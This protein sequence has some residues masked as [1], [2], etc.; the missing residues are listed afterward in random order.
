MML[1]TAM[2][3]CRSGDNPPGYASGDM[4]A[5]N[6]RWRVVY[7][8]VGQ[9]YVM[10][11]SPATM[12]VFFST[13]LVNAAVHRL[14]TLFRGGGIALNQEKLTNRFPEVR[15]QTLGVVS[16]PGAGH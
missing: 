14:C 12:N 13:Q 7:R 16:A 3:A 8:L 2:C 1:S 11:V 15:K 10:A 4:P 5:C 6:S 9:V